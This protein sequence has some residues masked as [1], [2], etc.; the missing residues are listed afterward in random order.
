MKTDIQISNEAKLLP[1]DEIA[2]NLGIDTDLLTHFGKYK[3]KIDLEALDVEK[4][5]GKLILVTAITPTPAGEG[6]TTTNV[7]LSMAL[8]KL[9][10]TAVT[11]IREPSLGP[12]FG[13]KGGA[14][15][16]GYAQ[17]VPMVDINLH[18][19]G[20]I[21]AITAANNLLSAMIDNSIYQGNPLDIDVRRVVWKRALDM[22]DR[23]LRNITIGLGGL[24]DGIPRQDGFNISVASEVMAIL[25][26]AESISDLKER[27]SRMI[28]AYD[29]K[30]NPVTCEQIG[31]TGAL[32]VLLYEAIK[33]NLV[34]TLENTPALIHGGPFANI[35][36]GCNSVLATKMGLRY[37]DYVVTEAGFG[38]DLGAE[39]F[40]DIKCRS[41]NLNPDGVVIVA[42][43]RAL[44]MHGGV[45]K[46]EL[47]QENVDAI[48]HGFANL[49]KHMENLDRFGVPYIVAL[50]RFPT[51]S[52]A[53][54]AELRRLMEDRGVPLA[55]SD[56]F[57]KGGEGGIEMAEMLLEVME[58]QKSEFHYLYDVED[59]IENK[60]R[61]ISQKIYGAD[62]VN[63]S[64]EAM[65]SLRL[66]EKIGYGNLPICMAKTQ[67]SFSD[68]ATKLGRPTDFDIEIR[69]LRLSAGAGFIVA[70]TG[71]IMTMPGLPKVP[72]A[73]NIDILPDGE[74]VGLF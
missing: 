1:I 49:E 68:D 43:I 3:A 64:K 61:T 50:N 69:E 42:T 62:S 35:A 28:V 45:K 46:D 4:E 18:F 65:T 11:A 26:L 27:L 74:I 23:A 32:S 13:M 55:L 58:N 17:V 63:F 36:H 70:I 12:S 37:A 71:A 9:G 52:D 16:G 15:G 6:K 66:F 53:E 67:Y 34:Q 24:G 29:R 72:A 20:D 39:K 10:K 5:D 60:I 2:K 8:N 48:S 59:T 25:C 19:T 33:P 30:R 54:V 21:H 56:V 40:F 31:A 14:A 22:N 51:D 41:A 57:S 73:N 7:G 47:S 44:K 38:A